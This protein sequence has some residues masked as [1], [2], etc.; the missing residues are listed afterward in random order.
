MLILHS[1]MS[2]V[3]GDAG[4]DYG[5]RIRHYGRTKYVFGN[6]IKH[7]DHISLNRDVGQRTT[8]NY[9]FSVHADYRAKMLLCYW[10]SLVSH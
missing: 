4:S 9:S 8:A 1:P 7:Y 3:V 10:R 6:V 2:Q 5:A